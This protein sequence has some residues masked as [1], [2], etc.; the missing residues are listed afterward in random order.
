MK[1]ENKI[2][3]SIS[4]PDKTAINTA[5]TAL[6]ALFE[7]MLVALDPDDRRTLAKMNDRSIPFVEKVVQYVDSNPE[8]VPPYVDTVEFKKDF[9]TF[10][11]LREFLRP[12][13]QMIANLE[14]TTMLSGSDAYEVARV[15]YQSV[16]LAAKMKVPNAQAIYD[17]LKSRFES[18]AKPKPPSPPTT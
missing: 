11:E 1:N 3:L 15:Y 10:M 13:L 2:S 6:A 7:P 9:Q 16:Q 8:F 12:L 17:D 5:I 18:N 14:G 4:N